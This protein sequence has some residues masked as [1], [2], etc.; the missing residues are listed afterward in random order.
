LELATTIPDTFGLSIAF[1]GPVEAKGD[2]KLARCTEIYSADIVDSPAANDSGLFEAKPAAS[3]GDKPGSTKQ[4]I[5]KMEDE[6][7]I[8]PL[9]ALSAAVAALSARLAKLEAPDEPEEDDEEDPAEMQ[10]KLEQVAEL[11]AKKALVEFAKT[12]GTPPAAPSSEAKAPDAEKSE[13]KTFEALVREHP[14]YATDKA[15]AIRETVAA[16]REAHTA[17]LARLAG[18]DVILF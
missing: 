7:K 10:A 16:N 12:L 6:K 13:A 17:Y 4:P 11:S 14:K 1:S 9:E 15:L 8:D 18:Q 3:P 2:L 5:T